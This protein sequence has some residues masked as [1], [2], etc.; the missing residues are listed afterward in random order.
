MTMVFCR[1]IPYLRRDKLAPTYEF[2]SLLQYMIVTLVFYRPN[3]PGLYSAELHV[4]LVIM[5]LAEAL[6]YFRLTVLSRLR[7]VFKTLARS[8]GLGNIR[9]VYTQLNPFTGILPGTSLV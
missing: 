7:V 1:F 8:W 4:S 6:L 9:P 2:R 5:S 3:S